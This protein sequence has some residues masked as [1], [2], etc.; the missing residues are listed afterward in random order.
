MS[1]ELLQEDGSVV[2]QFGL[3]SLHKD[4]GGTF[5]TNAITRTLAGFRDQPLGQYRL[6]V[7][8]L[9]DAKEL[10]FLKPHILIDRPFFSSR[11]IE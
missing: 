5:S 2:D 6:R 1:W 7:S 8:V 3:D 9:R 11:A 4:S 10:D